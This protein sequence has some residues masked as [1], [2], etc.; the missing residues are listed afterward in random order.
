MIFYLLFLLA[1]VI[2]VPVV[3]IAAEKRRRKRDEMRRLAAAR[4]IKEEVLNGK[5]RGND[6]IDGRWKLLVILRFYDGGMREV[7]L[8]PSFAIRFG[9]SGL[10][11][12]VTVDA[13]LVSAVHCVLYAVNGKLYVKDEHS[14][15]G[16]YIIRGMKR[17]RI[18]GAA[19]KEKDVLETGGVRFRIEPYWFDMMGV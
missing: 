15:N 17:Y 7:I 2:A 6:G 19:L 4:L 8:D 14:G 10:T 12:D 3:V 18:D 1:N 9:R 5:I 16:T 13:Q 11:N